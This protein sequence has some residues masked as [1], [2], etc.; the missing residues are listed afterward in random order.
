MGE[1]TRDAPTGDVFMGCNWGRAVREPPLRGIAVVGEG[2]MGSRRRGQRDSGRGIR[3]DTLGEPTRHAPTGVMCSWSCNGGRAVHEGPPLRGMA[4]RW[5][6]RDGFE[7]IAG[8][9]DGGESSTRDA[10]TGDVFMVCNGGRAFREPSLRGMVGRWRGGDG[11]P[12]SREQRVR[13]GMT[14]LGWQRGDVGRVRRAPTR[15]APTGD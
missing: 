8:M 5:R 7:G 6:G 14:R 15:D 12:P 11:F 9:T 3:N 10:P 2:V 13:V 4:L 1:P